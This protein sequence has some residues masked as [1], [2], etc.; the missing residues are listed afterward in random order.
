MRAVMRRRTLTASLFLLLCGSPADAQQRET[1]YWA[2][3]RAEELNMRVGP[4]A[5]FPIVWVYRRPGLP[6]KVLRLREGW[7]L[8][9][10]PDGARGWVV[11]RLLEDE[12]GVIVTGK[13]YA[14]M[15]SEPGGAGDLRWR[16]EP[17][18]VARL[19]ECDGNW[20]RIR[21]GER[22]GWIEAARLWGDESP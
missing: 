15:R 7:R 20:C 9:E 10:D 12:R 16:V 14:P 5:E 11:A 13:G 6:L 17:G 19:D 4:S 1:P 3:I 18:V 22:R 8:V 21:I 2:A